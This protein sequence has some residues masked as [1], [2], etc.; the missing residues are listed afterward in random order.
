MRW[1]FWIVS[2]WN[3]NLTE[4][5]PLE[6]IKNQFSH[7]RRGKLSFLLHIMKQNHIWHLLTMRNFPKWHYFKKYWRNN[8]F[9]IDFNAKFNLAYL[10]LDSQIWK[11]KTVKLLYLSMSTTYPTFIQIHPLE[12][13]VSVLLFRVRNP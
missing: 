6:M 8:I 4:L 11:S 2:L 5:S 9:S 3:T 7:K 1:K 10:P 13:L 12:V